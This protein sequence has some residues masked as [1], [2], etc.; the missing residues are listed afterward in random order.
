MAFRR[1]H[2]CLALL[3]VSGVLAGVVFQSGE[4]QAAPSRWTVASSPNQALPNISSLD[5]VSCVSPTSCV[6]V[7]DDTDVFDVS[8]QT[9]IE[10]WNGST[11]RI[12][13]SPSPGSPGSYNI[14]NGVSCTSSSTCVAV[15][16][17]TNG[18]GVEETLIESWNGTSWSVASS[19][20]P[21]SVSNSLNGVFCTSANNCVA[22]GSYANGSGSDESLVE[23]W[24]GTNWSVTSTPDPGSGGNTLYGVSCTSSSDCVAVGNDVD[25]STQTLVE[26]W[27][28][29]AWS[30]ASSP[31][32][33][34]GDIELDGVSC[35]SSSTCVAVGYDTN[36][37]GVTQTLVESWNGTAWS[38][39]SS[40]S[41]GSAANYLAGVSCTSA[42]SCVAVG[43]YA[44]ERGLTLIESWN[45][46]TWS[47]THSPNPK[48]I[49]DGDG[50]AGVSC[51]STINCVAVGAYTDT[52][53]YGQT[54]I[55]TG[56]SAPLIISGV[57][58]TG[59]ATHP[60]VTISGTG[61][62]SAPSS[63]P[64]GCGATGKDYT[65]D[66][67]YLQDLSTVW[68]AGMSGD[69]VGLNLISYTSTKIKFKLGSW[70]MAHTPALAS[71]DNFQV[72]VGGVT[73]TGV[74]TYF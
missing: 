31:S 7:G 73:T 24:N 45:G 48:T 54:L 2:V 25:G 44:V 71:G 40:P 51:A 20:S 50:L 34:S 9:L 46:T 13:P 66:S 69:C 39:A 53:G 19:P 55:E 61:F 62:G 22:V 11:W 74:V 35:T 67:L 43:L 52:S 4:A 72:G 10:S 3:A 23:S 28:G 12:V 18:S 29:T 36:G 32:P 5:G 63:V 37:S 57:K 38:V 42:N 70:Y 49:D 21:G 26:S 17:Y 65:D 1:R 30:V 41:P 15:G 47:M 56:S 58:F 6:A 33:G 14:L 68:N 8:G 60:V 16:Y 27:N 59:S 64:A